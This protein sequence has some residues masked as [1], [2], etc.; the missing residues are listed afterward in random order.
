MFNQVFPLTNPDHDAA[1]DF[2]RAVDVL[3]PANDDFLTQLITAKPVV[4]FQQFRWSTG[5]ES[6]TK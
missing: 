1:V 5:L 6:V 3:R 2:F 4:G